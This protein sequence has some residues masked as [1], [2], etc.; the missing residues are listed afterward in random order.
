MEKV[1]VSPT[2]AMDWLKKNKNNRPLRKTTVSKYAAIMA[3]GEWGLSCAS[4]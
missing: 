3:R 2:M 4:N 1:K